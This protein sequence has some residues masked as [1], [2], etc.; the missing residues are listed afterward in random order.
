MRNKTFGAQKTRF[1]GDTRYISARVT[2]GKQIT[3]PDN[4]L[5]DMLAKDNL[6]LNRELK[7]TK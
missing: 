2:K 1:E 4:L 7:A 3:S 6:V 5:T